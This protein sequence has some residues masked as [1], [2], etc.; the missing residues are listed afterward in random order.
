VVFLPL[1][2]LLLL[3]AEGIVPLSE[4][5]IGIARVLT[6][7]LNACVTLVLFQDTW[8]ALRA[9]PVS[10]RK[11]IATAQP[12]MLPALGVA[13]VSALAVNAGMA[14]L[15]I[16]GVVISVFLWVAIPA[17]LVENLGVMKSLKRSWK[18]VEGHGWPVFGALLL[19][20][21]IEKVPEYLLAK[22]VASGKVEI[23]TYLLVT[24]TFTIFS[25]AAAAAVIAVGY[26]D[27]R[28]TKEGMDHEAIAAVFD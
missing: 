2:V 28:V 26:H 21:L 22:G 8:E 25:W 19:F 12:R 11:S 16:P 4:R 14:M 5:G 10:I 27:L 13:I 9:R 3:I 15:V 7:I 24:T 18:L 20:G 1:G 17:C 6:G 23:S